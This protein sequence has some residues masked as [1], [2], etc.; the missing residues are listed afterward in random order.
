LKIKLKGQ[1]FDRIE[2]LEAELQAVLRTFTEQAF[3]DAL[4]KWQKRW[5]YCI[6]AEEEYFES[7]GGQ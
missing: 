7:D 2:V 3:Q 5:E 4:E 6:Q 1:H